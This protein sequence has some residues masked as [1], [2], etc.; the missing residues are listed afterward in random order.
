MVKR[1]CNYYK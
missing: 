1:S